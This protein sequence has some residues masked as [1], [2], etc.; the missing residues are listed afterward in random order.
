MEVE[1]ARFSLFLEWPGPCFALYRFEDGHG[2]LDKGKRA[3]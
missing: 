2:V 1:S 3:A